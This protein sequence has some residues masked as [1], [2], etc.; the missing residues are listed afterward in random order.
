MKKSQSWLMLGV[1]LACIGCCALPLYLIISGWAAVGAIAVL[2][3]ARWLEL[4]VCLLPLVLLV[5]YWVY[6]RKTQK[7]CCSST[8][9]RCHADQCVV[10]QTAVEHAKLQD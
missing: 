4:L 6:R 5:S 1:A 10:Q 7:A 8:E 9:N 2:W 3:N